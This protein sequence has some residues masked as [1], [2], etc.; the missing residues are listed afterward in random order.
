MLE[1]DIPGVEERLSFVHGPLLGDGTI[2]A[3]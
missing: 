3:I 1:L 2:R